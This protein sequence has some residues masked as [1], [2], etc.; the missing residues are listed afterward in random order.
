MIFRQSLFLKD[1]E[2]AQSSFDFD[3]WIGSQEESESSE[4]E[5][6]EL[7]LSFSSSESSEL[8]SSS[9]S[10]SLEEPEASC[11]FDWLSSSIRSVL[12]SIECG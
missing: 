10:A 8:P 9:S 5:D 11:M 12:R 1:N 7:L 6:D 3:S 2:A 4:D